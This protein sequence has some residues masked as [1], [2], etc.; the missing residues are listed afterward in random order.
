MRIMGILGII[1]V[2]S[3]NMSMNMG[4]IKMRSIRLKIRR[5]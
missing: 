2:M 4:R 5:I 3:R 1:V